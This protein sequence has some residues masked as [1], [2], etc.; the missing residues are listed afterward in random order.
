[1]YK[2]HSISKDYNLKM[3]DEMVSDE[4]KKPVIYIDEPHKKKKGEG[5][6]GE[7]NKQVRLH[8]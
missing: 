4:K 8:L 6:G 7:K 2:L 1:M 3:P 5:G